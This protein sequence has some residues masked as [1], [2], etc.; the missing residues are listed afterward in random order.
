MALYHPLN[1]IDFVQLTLSPNRYSI[2][3]VLFE[4]ECL[5]LPQLD[6]VFPASDELEEALTSLKPTYCKRRCTLSEFLDFAS[7]S[8]GG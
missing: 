7:K 5:T 2:V 6:I 1:S 4:A 3:F 8:P